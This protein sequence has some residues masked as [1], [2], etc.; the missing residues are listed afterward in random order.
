MQAKSHS[1]LSWSC[2]TA[3]TGLVIADF[4]NSILHGT[5]PSADAV[6]SLGESWTALAIYRA[7]VGVVLT[8]RHLHPLQSLTTLPLAS[9]GQSS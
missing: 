8:S 2:H 4:A 9:T 3:P 7:Q 6:E 5:T 1:Q